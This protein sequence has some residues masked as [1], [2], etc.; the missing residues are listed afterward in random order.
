MKKFGFLLAPLFVLGIGLSAA[1][2]SQGDVK[3]NALSPGVKKEVLVA[4]A[5]E[6]SMKQDYEK[7]QKKAHEEL[8]EYKQKMKGLEG[9][10]RTLEDKTKAEVNE[11][12]KEFHKEVNATEQKLKSMESAGAD[13]WEKMKSDVDSA[14]AAVK[15][16]YDKVAAH[17]KG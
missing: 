14:M 8:N 5:K 10:A 17:F 2:G 12:I 6:P 7:Y 9:K 3:T 16:E 4:Q 15:E 1:Y 11:G 13:A